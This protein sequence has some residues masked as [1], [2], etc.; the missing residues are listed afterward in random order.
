[1]SP[2]P[3]THGPGVA[4]DQSHGNSGRVRDATARSVRSAHARQ[5]PEGPLWEARTREALPRPTHH[6]VRLGPTQEPEE[7][8]KH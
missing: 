7:S 1:M 2:A 5:G 4:C 6:H 3:H 8:E